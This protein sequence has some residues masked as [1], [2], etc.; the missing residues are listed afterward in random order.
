MVIPVSS[1]IVV[2]GSSNTDMVIKTSRIPRP[3]E[4]ILGGDFF[5]NAGGKGANQAVAAARLGGNVSFIGKMGSDVFGKEAIASLSREKINTEFIFIDP[6]IPSGI[7]LITVDGHGENCIVVAPGANASLTIDDLD[8]IE[9]QIL[10]SSLILLQLEIPLPTVCH[11]AARAKKRGIPVI[12]N[13]APASELPDELLKNIAIITPNESEGEILSGIQINDWESAAIASRKLQKR[14]ARTVVLTLGP[15]GALVADA[16]NSIPIPG[17][18]VKAVDT[19]AAGDIFNG[20][21][22]VYLSAGHTLVQAVDFACRAAAISVTRLGAQ[23]SAPYLSEIEQ[24]S[25]ANH[26]SN[27]N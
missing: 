10:D 19:T 25:F 3:G 5:M 11:V 20:A 21:L 27:P 4:T 22:S 2:I 1:R 8:D 18:A 9:E 17:Y 15:R 12:L 26:E 16:E 23:D 13:P 14:G 24:F 7:A 6:V